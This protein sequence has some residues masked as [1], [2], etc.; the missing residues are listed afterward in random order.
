MSKPTEII[1]EEITKIEY[2]NEEN[3]PYPYVYDFSVED[4]ETF[5]V[6]NGIIVHNTLN[7]F[8]QCGVSSTN[9][10][11]G[12]P[13]IRELISVSKTINTPSMKIYL[14][15]EYKNNKEIA[16]QIVHDI[17]R[18]NFDYFV[19]N[20]SIWYD[21]DVFNSNI[22]TDYKFMRDHYS[23]MQDFEDIDIKTQ[24]SPYVL[25][26]QIHSL[27]IANKNVS[28]FEIYLFLLRKFDKKLNQIHI[29]YSDEIAEHNV[30]HIRL[31]H[32]N[33]NEIEQITT[34]STQSLNNISDNNNANKCINDCNKLPV[35]NNMSNNNNANKCINHCNKSPANNNMSD[36]NTLP[37]NNN[38]SV[39]QI[40]D[41]DYENSQTNINTQNTN[42]PCTYHPCT[43][44][45]YKILMEIEQELMSNCLFKGIDQIEKA[46]LL[47]SKSEIILQTIGT[48]LACILQQTKYINTQKTISNDIHEVYNTLGI[49][50]AGQVLAIELYEVLNQSCVNVNTAH[51]NLLVDTMTLIGLVS[52]NRYGITKAD[53]GVLAMASFEEPDEHFVNAA[54]YNIEENMNGTSSNIT[55]GQICPFGTGLVQ[56]EFDQSKFIK[57]S[58]LN[59]DNTNKFISNAKNHRNK[60]KNSAKNID[61]DDGD[62][63]YIIFSNTTQ[64]N[65]DYYN[66]FFNTQFSKNSTELAIIDKQKIELVTMDIIDKIINNIIDGII[67]KY[68][69]NKVHFKKICRQ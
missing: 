13:R 12:V 23:F 6:D 16:K 10:T 18:I 8:H 40:N 34:N 44:N 62:D 46:I 15:D 36:N 5:T 17:Q 31:I 30:F 29:I 48:N 53:N 65:N 61:D 47:E 24:L 9:V 11:Q 43:E 51:V 66:E 54:V 58:N 22:I 14:K 21:P 64:K 68:A 28:M 57:Y 56:L 25:R 42:Y 60:Q 59:H 37:M 38:M 69:A 32:K 27:F 41:N 2:I 4:I 39:T 45:D 19:D 49:E 63:D 67:E 55:M 52:M 20:T 26:I 1:W 7:T 33:I 35:N 3:Y 50:A